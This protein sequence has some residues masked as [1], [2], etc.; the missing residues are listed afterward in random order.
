MAWLRLSFTVAQAASPCDD[1]PHSSG[2]AFGTILAVLVSPVGL[3]GR[4]IQ[5]KATSGLIACGVVALLG[6]AGCSS[7][8]GSGGSAAPSWAKSL[9]TGVTVLAEGD[10]G[11]GTPGAVVQSLIG[12]EQSGQFSKVCSLTEPSA[13]SQCNS[14]ISGAS[15]AALASA[16]PTYKS[17]AVT[18]TAIDGDQA[19]V[20]VTGTVCTPNESPSCFTNTD[21]AAWFDSGKSFATLWSQSS[22]ASSNAY[23]L[24]QL[25]QVNG[26]WYA[27]SSSSSS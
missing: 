24:A 7:G 13:Q 12:D 2:E 4:E 3:I 17:I 16:M 6:V 15:A 8:G 14:A 19:L 27:Y 26:S 5:V 22:S 9:G 11:S 1:S 18:W 20:G 21:P 25:I 23:S 10:A